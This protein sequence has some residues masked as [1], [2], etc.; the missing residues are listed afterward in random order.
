M[1]R[2][3]VLLNF[4]RPSVGAD[5]PF[6]CLDEF[7]M[8][9]G[10]NTGNMA[11]LHALMLTVHGIKHAVERPFREADI[12]I[13]GCS[14]FI[15]ARRA[16]TVQDTEVFTDGK[17]LIA[18]GLGAQA[19]SYGD[20]LDI[21]EDTLKWLEA[22]FAMA[23]TDG[24]SISL[25]GEYTRQVLA[26]Y[27]FDEQCVVL[28]CPSLYISPDLTLGA[29]I[30]RKLEKPFEF[31]GAAPGNIGSVPQK[32]LQLERYLARLVDRYQGTYLL[33]HPP[34]LFSLVLG[35]AAEIDG[36]FA[37]KVRDAILP[38]L[39]DMDFIHWMRLHGR[40]FDNV[41]SWLL[42]LRSLD[43]V[44][45]T[46]IHGTQ[47]A[48]QAGTPAICVAVDARQ[49]ELCEIMRIPYIDRAD[50]SDDLGLE[51]IRERLAAADWDAF[52]ANR[53]R[54]AGRFKAFLESN[55]VG[56]S[57]QLARLAASH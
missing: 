36:K 8:R 50:L 2:A 49:L 40:L 39:S 17:P 55:G 11:F 34:E 52:D 12:K 4:T 5:V 31:V 42:H 54:L 21:P 16:M 6:V 15:S 7:S 19:S 29:T 18:V 45:S 51:G 41:P 24:P 32:H 13:W 10:Q 46:R 25:R 26:R 30:R 44:V 33:Q 57:G 9:M 28:G 35:N 22:L 47:L 43:I 27:G 3:P 48:L 53:R 20:T 38:D 56:A 1:F 14:N 23:P 37:A